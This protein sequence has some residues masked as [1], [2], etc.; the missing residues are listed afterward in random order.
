MFPVMFKSDNIMWLYYTHM[1]CGYDL[2]VMIVA[3]QAMHPGSNPGIRTL[4][5]IFL[6]FV[7][8]I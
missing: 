8:T 2:V 3:S 4:M 7:F 1:T 6:P 5:L